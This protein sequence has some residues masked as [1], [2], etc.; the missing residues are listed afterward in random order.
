MI[1][2]FAIIVFYFL[3]WFL[4]NVPT[5]D[6]L[7]TFWFLFSTQI[8][9]VIFFAIMFIIAIMF[10]YFKYKEWFVVAIVLNIFTFGIIVPLLTTNTVSY[11]YVWNYKIF[12]W[13]FVLFYILTIIFFELENIKNIKEKIKEKMLKNNE[14]KEKIQKEEIQKEQIEN[15]DDNNSDNDKIENVSIIEEKEE[16]EIVDYNEKYYNIFDG[17]DKD[18]KKIVKKVENVF[19]TIL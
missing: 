1:E 5:P 14:K 12:E 2:I 4:F 17:N 16:H 13:L 9:F 6:I 3:Y 11:Q 18:Y 19:E 10:A 15:N 8:S 7:K